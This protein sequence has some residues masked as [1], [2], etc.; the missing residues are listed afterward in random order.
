MVVV[1][2]H[3][4]VMAICRFADARRTSG[5]ILNLG[6]RQDRSHSLGRHSRPSDLAMRRGGALPDPWFGFQFHRVPFAYGGM[7]LVAAPYSTTQPACAC[8]RVFKNSKGPV[9]RVP[10]ERLPF[11]TPTGIDESYGWK[12]RWAT[13][14]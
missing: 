1:S 4:F 2:R 8:V 11:A 9:L 10:L 13:T 7:S 6:G 5:W 14:S 12:F 3:L